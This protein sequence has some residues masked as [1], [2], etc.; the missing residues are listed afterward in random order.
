MQDV[1][2]LAKWIWYPIDCKPTEIS[3]LKMGSSTSCNLHTHEGP[4][5]TLNPIP[6]IRRGQLRISSFRPEHESR[7]TSERC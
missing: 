5:P 4:Q 2:A 6:E 7:A 1:L 3:S